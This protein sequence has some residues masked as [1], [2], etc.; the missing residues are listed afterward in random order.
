MNVFLY[1]IRRQES[2][3][4][5]SDVQ[6]PISSEQERNTCSHQLHD[7]LPKDDVLQPRKRERSRIPRERGGGEVP[8]RYP[9]QFT[10]QPIIVVPDLHDRLLAALSTCSEQIRIM[11][12]R[13][14]KL[15]MSGVP[16]VSRGTP[17]RLSLPSYMF[18]ICCT[19]ILEPVDLPFRQ[20]DC[21]YCM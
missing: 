21:R 20:V 10:L 13:A 5:I 17:K 16:N 14:L 1:T 19:R 15:A 9:D 8:A 12:H 18:L 4:G 11:Q 2:S 7:L 6:C 3:R